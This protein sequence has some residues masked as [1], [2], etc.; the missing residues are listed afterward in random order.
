MNFFKKLRLSM[1]VFLALLLV[2][3]ATVLVVFT[4]IMPGLISKSVDEEKDQQLEI[5]R[6]VRESM[7]LE[8]KQ[9]IK[10]LESI[11]NLEETKSLQTDIIDDVLEKA[12][13]ITQFY[14]YFFILD[15]QG[16]WLSYPSHEDLVGKTIRPDNIYWVDSTF[17]TGKTFFMDIAFSQINTLVSG[18]STP[19]YSDDLKT[20]A[21]LRGVIVVSENNIAFDLIRDITIGKNGFVYIV[22]SKGELIAHPHYFPAINDFGKTGYDDFTPVRNVIEGE[23][24]VVEYQYNGAKWVA[25]YTPVGYTGWGVIAQQP[26]ADIT[27]T[28]R[29]QVNTIVTYFVALIFLC[30]LIIGLM[31]N[32]A[33]KPLAKLV[34]NLENNNISSGPV[35]WANDEIGR[36]GRKF[37]ELFTNLYLSNENLAITIN[38]I[39]EGVIVTDLPG[40]VI[41]LN[42]VAE[43]LTGWKTEEAIGKPL[44]QVFNIINKQTRSKAENPVEK[45]IKLGRVQGLANQTILVSKNGSEYLIANTAA[46]ITNHDQQTVGV[47]LVC[48]DVTKEYEMLEKIRANEERL[49]LAL[50]G[51]DLGMWDWNIITD[52]VYFNRRWGEML[53]YKPEEIENNIKTWKKLIHPDE[54]NYVLEVLNAHLNGKNESYE[55]EHRMLAKDGS[56]KW[57]L[58]KGRVTERDENRKPLRA[59]GTHLD[60]TERKIAEQKLKQSNDEYQAINEKLTLSLERIE[61]INSELEIARKKAEES[62]CL[63]TA[64][65]ANLSHEIRTPMNGILG[66]STLLKDQEI[67]VT[68]HKRYVEMIEQSGQRMLRLIND[69]VDISRIESGQVNIELEAINLNQFMERVYLFFKPVAKHKKLDFSYK[70]GLQDQKCNFLMDSMKLEQVTTNL[71]N[72]AFKFTDTGHVNFEYIL[73]DG[74]L[75]FRIED[76]GMGIPLNMHE[77]IFDRFRQVENTYGKGTEGSGLGLSISKA[78]IELMGGKIWVESEP[79]KGSVFSFCL[80]A[81]PEEKK[82]VSKKKHPDPIF[83][84]QINVL[85]AEDDEVSFMYLEVILKKCGCKI[86]HARNGLEAVQLFKDHPDINIV[87]MDMKMP[88]MDGLEAT[89][90]IKKL[91]PEIPVI[92]QTAYVT[93]TD[94]QKAFD[95]GCSDFITK[96]IKKD[97]LFEIIKTLTG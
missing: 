68:T 59:A 31:L 56:W 79:D 33:L 11:A 34:R 80:P 88:E 13:I 24:G 19:I 6:Q 10:E 87:L 49:S 48:K 35:T 89:K 95:A 12:N 72:N 38:S 42:K 51:A 85:V 50:A 47:V 63:K 93:E 28:A 65:L 82:V 90:E 55:T 52:E 5:A 26:L 61:K 17:A 18:F 29:R 40:S 2:I 77:K 76:T 16:R 73:K 81:V 94:K 45:A 44:S 58:D 75:E 8:F 32:Y 20:E 53:G 46:P 66:F 4:V 7:S 84:K 64:F 15:R 91:R 97:E 74:K 22:S 41:R 9:A 69:L 70:C 86:L 78:Y 57:I 14:N 1:K 43:D 25:A 67:N 36:I 60:I 27:A 54:V 92:A 96:P 37:E 30:I 23:S 21:L 62:D 83:E 71:L 39:G 3:C